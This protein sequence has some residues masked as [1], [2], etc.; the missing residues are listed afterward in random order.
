MGQALQKL[1]DEQVQWLSSRGIDRVT[2]SA[3]TNSVFPG[4]EFASVAMYHDYC[5]A[6]KLDPLKKPA[7]IVPMPVRNAQTGKTVWRDVIMAGI[8][9]HRTTA[10]RTGEYAG[11][12]EIEYGPN[13]TFDFGGQKIEAPEWAKATVYRIIGGQRCP[14]TDKVY[15]DEAA[16][17]KKDG[18][19]NS[20]W[21]KRKRGQIA[22]CA[23]AG[24]LRKGFPEELGGQQTIEEMEGAVAAEPIDITPAKQTEVAQANAAIETQQDNEPETSVLDLI[25]G[26]LNKAA[27][28]QQLDIVLSDAQ[29][30]ELEPQQREQITAVHA[31]RVNALS[32]STL[33]MD[34]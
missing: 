24:A 34:V 31:E 22:K 23:E 7:H 17:T 32:G 1:T 16:A 25:I 4:A 27:D 2:W 26:Q 8:Y 28:R 11:Q 9:E 5:T 29:V 13:K 18:Q 14:F 33:E 20:M 10:M 19:L 3:L 21:T 15:F 6:R 12:D 30:Y